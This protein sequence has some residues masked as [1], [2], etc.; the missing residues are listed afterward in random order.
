MT[1]APGRH[2]RLL[3]SLATL[4]T[5]VAS[6]AALAPLRAAAV[7]YQDW[8]TYLHDAA[9]TA[10]SN[11]AILTSNNATALKKKWS[12]ATGGSIVASPAIVNGT[13]YVGSWDGYEYSIDG[14]KGALNWKTSLGQTNDPACNPPV[15][16]VTSGAT[17]VNGVLYAGGGDANWYALDA[18]SGAVLWSVPTGDDRQSGSQYNNHSN[19]SS[20]LIVGNAA[21]I[22]IASNCDNPLVPGQLLKVDLTSHQVVAS[23]NFVPQGQVGGGIWTTPAYDAATNIVYVS[24]GT[25]NQYN[26]TLSQ[27]VLAIDAGSLA[28]KDHWQLPFQQAVLDSDFGTTP[29]LTSDSSGRKLISVANKNGVLYTF[30]RCPGG[31]TCTSLAAGPVWQDQLAIG[32]DCPTCGDGTISSGA[33]APSA[34]VNGVTGVLFYGAGNVEVNGVGHGGSV[35]AID[36]G[37]GNV[38]WT[39]PTF[40]PVF[41]SLAYDNGLVIYAQGPTV[42]VIS[43][44]NGRSLYDYT[45]GAPFYSAP[46][47][48]H[49]QIIIGGTDRNVYAF[50]LPSSTKT[51]PADNNCPAGYTCQDIRSPSPAGSEVTNA[52]GSV[53][54]TASGA[55]IHGTSDQFRYIW[56]NGTGSSQLVAEVTQQSFQ[57]TQP[58]A[59]IMYRQSADPASPYYAVLEYPNDSFEN[60][61]QPM[62]EVWYRSK[63]GGTAIELDKSYPAVLPQYLLIQRRGDVF[64]ASAS[65]DGTNYTIIPGTS[66]TV[67]MPATVMQG[68]AADSGNSTNM[69]TVTYQGMAFGALSVS[70]ALPPSAHPCAAGF[71]CRDVGLP[72]PVGDQTLSNGVWT[73]YGAG[74]GVGATQDSF[75]FVGESLTGDVQVSAQLTS[76]GTSAA[77]TTQ[78][79]VMLR[80]SFDPG[81]SYYG[82]LFKPNAGAIVQWR[83]NNGLSTR[84]KIPLPAATLPAYV[85]IS[86]YTDTSA[87]PNVTYYSAQTSTDGTAW[88][89]VIGSTVALDFGGG[90]N[91]PTLAG[92][93]ATSGVNH[94]TVATTFANLTFGT[95]ASRP[96]GVCPSGWTCEDVGV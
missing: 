45:T 47:I 73:N 71:I 52:D 17:L 72:A 95:T 91:G 32:G 42:E 3:A 19:W 20:P 29:V 51:P 79:G 49:G 53:T 18:N 31:A 60:L 59:G 76:I 90:Q 96:P 57:N 48:S 65:T 63:F 66:Q 85:Q 44:A 6:V 22:G 56:A 24:T 94:Q 82:I 50:G 9:R 21:Y 34:T 35:S 36:P 62:I 75:H 15:L 83:V 13:V 70:P 64:S 28:V 74:T 37:T 92:T 61:P 11:E 55:A 5:A 33:F 4:V 23:V 38:L 40:Q 10:A 14:A 43:A 58:Q 69:G 89:Q 30:V 46:A 67:V 8:P 84:V 16:G 68:F 93:V 87:T 86:R 1:H 54:V 88:S 2:A 25:L 80:A 26:Q 78:A 27:A 7:T 81:S 41:G 77:A 39:H 12:Y